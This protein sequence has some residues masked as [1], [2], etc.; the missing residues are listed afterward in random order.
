MNM[1]QHTRQIQL[2]AILGLV[3]V[4]TSCNKSG[5]QEMRE[6]RL[7]IGEWRPASP[8]LKNPLIIS[9][10][11]DKLFMRYKTQQIGLTFK[12]G[13]YVQDHALGGRILHKGDSIYI[14]GLENYYVKYK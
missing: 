7:L 4:S 5:D 12:D 6:K 11:S 1:A 2:L 10:E 9:E 14:S 13:A 8:Y 3:A